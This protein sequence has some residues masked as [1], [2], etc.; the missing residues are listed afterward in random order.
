MT[1]SSA[2]HIHCISYSEVKPVN[3]EVKKGTK[4]TISCVITGLS[5]TAAVA[6][7][8]KS[9]PVPEDKFTSVQG[10][11]SEEKQSSGEK[12]DPAQSSNS[13]VTQTSTLTVDGTEVTDDTA[14][15]CRVTSGALPESGYSDTTVS[16]NTYGGLS[17][18]EL[19]ENMHV[20]TI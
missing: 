9:G 8:T 13:L 18:Y 1:Y 15:T 3:K 16:L 10:S 12:G 20:L 19:L 7:R 14:Y 2:A 11:A 6:W 5:A 4:T 17:F